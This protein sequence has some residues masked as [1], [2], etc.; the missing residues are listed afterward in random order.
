MGENERQS[1]E[2]DVDQGK[3]D[4]F[5]VGHVDEERVDL[6]DRKNAVGIKRHEAL[7]RMIDVKRGQSD[8]MALAEDLKLKGA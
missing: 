2:G 1:S 5:N 6:V 7:E 8:T 3:M 4:E